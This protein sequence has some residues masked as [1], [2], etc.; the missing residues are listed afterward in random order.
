MINM[1][2]G[3]V[4]VYKRRGRSNSLPAKWTDVIP[5]KTL[6]DLRNKNIE[7]QLEGI[8][9]DFMKLHKKTKEKR[10]RKQLRK[11][12]KK[13]L[14][15]S[16]RHS[17]VNK[18][19]ILSQIRSE[20]SVI[21]VFKPHSIG[22]CKLDAKLLGGIQKV[23]WGYVPVRRVNTEDYLAKI[24]SDKYAF[25]QGKTKNGVLFN[26][27]APWNCYMQKAIHFFGKDPTY[28][29][30]LLSVQPI[31]KNAL[32]P[33]CYQD[34]NGKVL[35]TIKTCFGEKRGA[36]ELVEI[37]KE[38]GKEG[39]KFVHSKICKKLFPDLS[40]NIKFKQVDLSKQMNVLKQ[41]DDIIYP[42]KFDAFVRYVNTD[43]EECI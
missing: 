12:H 33:P 42:I 31:E 3:Q 36:F 39:L 40:S 20:D 32:Y 10:A 17:E 11:Q 18:S 27:H 29:H 6:N 9:S 2:E 28:G 16:I 38:D 25:I 37:K 8:Y 34:M 26:P 23:K 4:G 19:L 5:D 14:M 24:E 22:K 21:P 35:C 15:F 1:K 7:F 30:V 43:N 13:P 41:I